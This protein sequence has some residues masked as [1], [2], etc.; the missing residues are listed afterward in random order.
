MS[1]YINVETEEGPVEVAIDED[2]T[3]DLQTVM[4][5]FGGTLRYINED[6]GHYRLVKIANGK[7]Q[8]PTGG[9]ETVPVYHVAPT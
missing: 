3:I 4:T 9:W 8:P 1:D 2:G 7:L 6:T 5:N